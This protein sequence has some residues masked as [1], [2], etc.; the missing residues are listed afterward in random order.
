LALTTGATSAFTL[1]QPWV[2]GFYLV[3]DVLTKKNLDIL[4][5]VI[6]LLLASYAGKEIMGYYQAYFSQS[7]SAKTMH[8]I[9]YDLFYHL[10]QLPVRFFDNSRT[11]ELVARIISDTD[12]V[13]KVMTQGISNNGT[14][15]TTVVGTFILL[16]YV[17]MSLAVYVVPVSA[18]L[19]VSVILFKKP[20]KIASRRIRQAVGELG[21]KANEVI[22]G[23]R[24]VKSFS[25]EKLEAD[26]FFDK[27]LGISQAKIRLAKKSGLY[28][29]TVDML[30]GL[31]IVI[32]VLFGAPQVV[33]GYL[34]LGALVAFIGLVDKLFRPVS[35][36]S[37]ANVDIQ[38]AV[39]A[40]ERIFDIM[41][42]EVES[43]LETSTTS[44]ATTTTNDSNRLIELANVKGEIRFEN[45]SF[46]YTPERPIFENFNL[47]IPAGQTVAIVGKSGAGKST[48]VNLI[49]RFY[50][51]SS[52]SIFIDSY[53]SHG[54][55]LSSIR[56]TIA[57]VSQDPVLF[58]DSIR[59]NIAYGRLNASDTEIIEVA[60]AANAHE[61]IVG[62]PDGYN[63]QVGER[64]AKLS[65]GQRQRIAIARA[66]LKNPS[67][68][69]LDEATSNVDSQSEVLIKEA[70]DRLVGKKTTIIIAHRL[71]TIVNS[72]K[73]VVLE[74]GEI[75]ETGGHSELLRKRGIYSMLYDAQIHSQGQQA[76]E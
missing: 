74:N 19:V 41:D 66:L 26:Q 46:G 49:L 23:V 50:D 38:R 45:V 70:L 54:L 75:V 62:L 22:A 72:D 21:A 73:I 11:G 69:I 36:L 31:A 53:P 61:F 12:E 7:L 9:R 40:G 28:S 25:M 30:A 65:T 2:L 8:R 34:G 71:S 27:S 51:P 24:I 64:G 37:K 15:L 63:S 3:G 13:D 35:S 42:R 43:H 68:L 6:L 17:N 20:L 33:H 5:W 16:F 59:N 56:H 44:T 4:P 32:V 48:L 52:G 1:L 57:V 14:D 29:G 10:E 60:R 67:I 47:M 76:D 55:K 39:V 18:A 58:S